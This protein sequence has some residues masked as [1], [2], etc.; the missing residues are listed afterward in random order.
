MQRVAVAPFMND[1]SG[2]KRYLEDIRLFPI[3]EPQ[4]E[5]MLAKRWKEY[6]RR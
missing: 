1:S 5:Y 6:G 4:Q 2:L 3:L